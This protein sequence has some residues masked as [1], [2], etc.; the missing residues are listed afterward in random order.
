MPTLY[1]RT[2]SSIT[3]LEAMK[4]R[5]DAL[6]NGAKGVALLYSPVC[7]QFAKVQPDGTLTDSQGAP[8]DLSMVFEARAFNKISELR[9]LNKLDGEGKAVLLSEQDI[10]GF[11]TDSIPDLDAID[12]IPQEYLLWGK[13]FTNSSSSNLGWGKLASSRIGSI[14]VPILGLTSNRR[15]Y[16]K[17]CE[18]LSE[19]DEHGNVA[20]VEERLIE[21]EVR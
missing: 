16:L 7:C 9:W 15:V 5:A 21:L 19:V 6:S 11:S 20:V 13:G 12:T 4:K 2:S 17:A 1:G 18:Y 3:L 8:I 14:N 10:S